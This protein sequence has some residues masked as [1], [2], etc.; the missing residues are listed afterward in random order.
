MGL[1]AAQTGVPP[2]HHVDC[3]L[4]FTEDKSKNYNHLTFMKRK[5]I[6]CIKMTSFAQA[7]LCA[8]LT[9]DVPAVRSHQEACL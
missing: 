3:S 2:I 9:G 8:A 6:I 5:C 4:G 1:A 7:S